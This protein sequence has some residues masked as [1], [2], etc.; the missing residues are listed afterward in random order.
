MEKEEERTFN[1]LRVPSANCPSQNTQLYLDVF[2]KCS[3]FC[4]GNLRR[5]CTTTFR[6]VYRTEDANYI[7]TSIRSI[8]RVL[9]RFHGNAPSRISKTL[10]TNILLLHAVVDIHVVE[11][12]NNSEL[13]KEQSAPALLQAQGPHT[14]TLILET[15]ISVVVIVGLP[16]GMV[17]A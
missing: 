4:G 1:L 6:V 17:N 7:W 12:P 16:F 13:L 9:R 14:L 5:E 2:Q 15:L 10:V 3:E 11:S 8:V